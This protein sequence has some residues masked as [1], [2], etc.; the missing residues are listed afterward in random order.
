MSSGDGEASDFREKLVAYGSKAKSGRIPRFVS[1]EICDC[2]YCTFE[3]SW[4]F[5]WRKEC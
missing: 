1:R 5:C 2:S 3:T 4:F